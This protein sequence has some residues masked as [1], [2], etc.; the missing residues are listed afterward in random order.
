[1]Y[2]IFEMNTN[3]NVFLLDSLTVELLY[4]FDLSGSSPYIALHLDA[5]MHLLTLAWS[6]PTMSMHTHNSPSCV[7]S[8]TSL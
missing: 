6:L 5:Y 8:P 3:K 1:M 4:F 7:A 2:F